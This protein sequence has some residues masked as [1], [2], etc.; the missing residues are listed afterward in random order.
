MPDRRDYADEY[1][2]RQERARAEGFASDYD[3]RMRR[4][5]PDADLPRST[6]EAEWLRGHRGEGYLRDYAREGDVL[7][8][9][10]RDPNT[11]QI[12]TLALYPTDPDRDVRLVSIRN[13]S[14]DELLDLFDDL[15]AEGVAVDMAGY[16]GEEA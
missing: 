5:D 2:R 3:R 15:A 12:D 14:T 16:F 8:V 9:D 4:G 11:G 7:Q 13:L 1:R 6:E 10:S